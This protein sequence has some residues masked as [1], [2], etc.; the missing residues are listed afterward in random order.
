MEKLGNVEIMHPSCNITTIKDGRGGIF[1][2][3]PKEPI[4]EFNMLYFR[5]EK[6]RGNHYHPEFVEYFLIV[7]GSGIFVTPNPEGGPDL[8]MHVSKGT[9]FRT[10]KNTAHAFHAITDV[11][12]VSM[13]TKPWDESRPP[14]VHEDLIPFDEEY[15]EYAIE[16]NISNA[17][18][19]LQIKTIGVVGAAGFVGSSIVNELRNNESFRVVEVFREDNWEIKLKNVDIIIYAANSGKRFFAKNNPHEDYVESVLKFDKLKKLFKKTKIILISSLSARTEPDH[20]YGKNRLG[21]E[22]L[23]HPKND[24]I[25][26]LGPMFGG[27]KNAGA[28][29]DILENKKVFLSDETRY[30]YVPVEYNAKKI[31][32]RIN[33]TG[34]IESGAKNSIGLRDLAIALNSTSLFEGRND[35][36]IPLET[37]SDAPDARDVI[38]YALSIK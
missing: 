34:I 15:N 25:F 8:N 31:V 22:L 13:L 9:C 16:N 11:T 38:K 32:E 1:T 17:S 18:N 35:T 2:W 24:L 5:P 21:C 14:I 4:L 27:G 29:Y 33:S 19:G 20:P 36:Q 7:E 10:P 12:A 3:I 28:L 6:I 26:R 37:F 23:V 30:S